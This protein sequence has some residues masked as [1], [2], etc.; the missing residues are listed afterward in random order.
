MRLS[1]WYEAKK[2]EREP[3]AFITIDTRSGIINQARFI[4]LRTQAWR[5]SNAFPTRNILFVTSNLWIPIMNNTQPGDTWKAPLY[6]DDGDA[7]IYL[8]EVDRKQSVWIAYIPM[9]TY[10]HR[11]YEWC[12]SYSTARRILSDYTDGRFKKDNNYKFGEKI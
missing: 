1:T 7:F 4:I 9:T 3:L 2:R 8:K 6:H 10:G 5:E 12:L 11:V